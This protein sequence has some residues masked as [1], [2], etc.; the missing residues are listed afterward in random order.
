MTM[1]PRVSVII[2]FRNGAAELP[3][4]VAALTQQT[5]PPAEFEVLLVDDAS[6]DGGADW[7]RDRLRPGWQLLSHAV[8][9]GSYAARNTGLK[10]ASAENLA[11]T[12]VDCRPTADWLEQG[13]AAL[14]ASPRVAGRIH[15]EHSRSPSVVELVDMGRFFRQHQYVNEGFA[16]TANLFARRSVFDT[17][18]GFDEALRWGGDYEIGRRCLRAGIPIVYSERVVVNHHPRASLGDLLR[19]GEH[20]GYGAGQI[21]RRGGSSLGALVTRGAERLRLTRKRGLRER[22]IQITQGAQ[23]LQVTAV[24]LLVMIATSLGCLRGYMFAN[25]RQLAASL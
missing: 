12:D 8:S 17:V 22:N 18:G 4:L 9:R 10:H 3:A 1:A 7:L 19:K 13:V 21:A 23:S 6:T 24:M 5:L 16:A 15:F 20:V 14:A 2:P 11:F 25:R